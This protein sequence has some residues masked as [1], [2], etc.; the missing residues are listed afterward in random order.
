MSRAVPQAR[1]AQ[2]SGICRS[3]L[4]DFHIVTNF[5]DNR[6]T[7]AQRWLQWLGFTLGAPQPFGVA[8]AIQTLLDGEH[9]RP[10]H[11]ATASVC[12]ALHLIVSRQP[13]V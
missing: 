1:G 8:R 5:V 12:P 9:R 11:H 2:E 10:R 3:L 4:D 6:N 7:K 13:H